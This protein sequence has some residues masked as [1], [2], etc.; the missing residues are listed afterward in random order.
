MVDQI[1]N[2]GIAGGANSIGHQIADRVTRNIFPEKL[3]AQINGIEIDKNVSTVSAINPANKVPE[4]MSVK[5]IITGE[6]GKGGI[7]V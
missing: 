1:S 6:D 2:N 5:H 3:L 4:D 7:V